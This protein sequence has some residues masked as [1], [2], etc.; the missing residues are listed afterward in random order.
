MSKSFVI[1][2]QPGVTYECY[3]GYTDR[4]GNRVRR[5]RRYYMLRDGFSDDYYF[6]P[7]SNKGYA[8]MISKEKFAS[9]FVPVNPIE[10]CGE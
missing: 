4:L 10:C 1:K 5:N 3:M 7:I 6:Y 2:A 9:H 8:V